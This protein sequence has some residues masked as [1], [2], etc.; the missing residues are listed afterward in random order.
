MRKRTGTAILLAGIALLTIVVAVIH[1]NTRQ[2][3]PEGEMRIVV[4]NTETTLALS[5]LKL[6]QV[7]GTIVNG[8]GEERTIDAQGIPVCTVLSQAEITELSQVKV[9]ADDEYHAVLT[10]EEAL[11]PEGV[12]FI[13]QEEGGV[14]L[15]VFGDTNSKRNVS[16]VVC[17]EV[18]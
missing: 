16:D 11:A 1:L 10:A 6:T 15:I 5:D 14:Q 17:M 3:V 7:T 4:G 2:D 13:M 12:Y 18:S 9:I 8:K